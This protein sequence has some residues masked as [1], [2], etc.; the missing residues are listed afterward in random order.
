MSKA[1]HDTK[2][3]NVRTNPSEQI[4]ESKK[5]ADIEEND[6][7]QDKSSEHTKM[8]SEQ[9]SEHKNRVS[10]DDYNY[11]RTTLS[12]RK[13]TNKFTHLVI[14]AITI[15][16]ELFYFWSYGFARIFVYDL[17][18]S[19][20]IVLSFGSLFYL[21]AYLV[22]QAAIE[23]HYSKYHTTIA[24]YE[25]ENMQ[26]IVEE[27]LF[28]SSLRMSYKYLDQYYSQTREQAR[29][30]FL[31]TICVT[32]VGAV[33]LTLGIISMFIDKTDASKITVAS[34]VIVEFISTIMFYLYNRTVQSMG[35]YHDKLFLSQNVAMALKVSD[36]IS[37]ENRDDIKSQIVKELITNVNAYIVNSGDENVKSKESRQDN[38]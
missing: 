24:R 33:L 2:N 28:E 4:S 3:D 12:R 8:S 10:L 29:N 35:N 19:F 30:G 7:S 37:D 18:V 32:I 20:I 15:V 14:G 23:V 21:L 1:K 25:F 36:S 27:N 11:A 16:L 38:Q 6:L 9:I 22:C 34:G 13:R 31:I 5:Q 26:E 17:R